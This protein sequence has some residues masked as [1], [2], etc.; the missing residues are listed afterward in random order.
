MICWPLWKLIGVII[1][2][3]W[4]TGLLLALVG[5]GVLRALRRCFWPF[6]LLTACAHGEPLA[7]LPE[8]A[9]DPCETCWTWCDGQNTHVDVLYCT[10]HCNEVC[11]DGGVE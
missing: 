1:G 3:V 8:D 7:P 6:V 10:Q 11:W 4:V 9:G 2:L 5:R